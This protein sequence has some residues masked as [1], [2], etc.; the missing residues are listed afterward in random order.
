MQKEKSLGDEPSPSSLRDATSPERGRFCSTYRKMVKSSPF[1]GAAERSE[2]ERV[3]AGRSPL[4]L[5]TSFAA[6]S[7]KGTPLAVAAKF[8]V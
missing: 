1:G 5:L 7:P 8:P 6:S 3:R 4:S 2:A